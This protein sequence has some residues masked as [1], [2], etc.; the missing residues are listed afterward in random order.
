MPA[1]YEMLQ[2]GCK[3]S[4]QGIEKEL[5]QVEKQ[6][7]ELIKADEKIKHQYT[8]APLVTGIGPVTACQMIVCSGELTKMQTGKQLACYCGVVPFAYSSGS[9][10]PGRP[11]GSHWAHKKM[12]SYLHRAALSAI[13]GPGELP[14]YYERPLGK[15]KAKMSVLNAV[16][17]KLVLRVCACIR[18]NALYDPHYMYQAA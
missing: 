1:S 16:R 18:D 3:A 7:E 10:V 14:T 4:L 12:K 9:S 2:Q 15:G 17:N 6:L 5:K 11:R 8:I 13:Q